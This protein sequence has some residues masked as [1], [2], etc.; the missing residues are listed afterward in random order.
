M[1]YRGGMVPPDEM[2]NIYHTFNINKD[3]LEKSPILG[4]G[5]N[6]IIFR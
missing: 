6:Q 3:T 1:G 5:F 4:L 2:Q